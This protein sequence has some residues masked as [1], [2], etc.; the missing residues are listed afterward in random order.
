MSE[1]LSDKSEVRR[2][3]LTG[4]ST[5]IVS[6]PKKWVT[7]HG[8][9]AKD[10]VRVEWRPSGNLRIIPEVTSIKI[11]REVE[12]NLTEIP[13][14]FVLD[15]LIGA[16]LSG[17]QLIRIRTKSGFGREYRRIFRSFI[18]STRGI[19]I[20]TEAENKIEML[21]LLNPSEMPLYSTMNRMYLLISS[22]IRD[23]SDVLAGHE[24][25]VLDDAEEREKEID[26]LRFLME[27]QVGLILESSRLEESMG[28]NR[29]EAAEFSRV[30]RAFERMGDHSFRICN[31]ISDFEG[32]ELPN[33]SVLLSIIPI[34]QN[35]MKLL[36]SNFRK[37]KIS[38]VH[39]AKNQLS[40]AINSLEAFEAEL[41]NSD[42]GRVNALYQ[43]RLS[44]SL[45]RICAY[46]SDM[47]EILINI[48]NHRK[49]NE[50]NLA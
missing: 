47:A 44:E 6:L 43:D 24:A 30:V 14:E 49:S 26:A 11:R 12:I 20:T 35:S 22:Q 50:V 46:S 16:Y 1:S 8:L 29:W 38:E 33:D 41:W 34:W 4:G 15:H 42:V 21:S 2:L 5:Y 40:S 28:T 10:Q 9:A 19:E 45:R 25:S 31:L 39:D 3:Q 17:A 36:I 18:Q 23:I 13:D 7:D 48:H 27:R 37:N 32:D